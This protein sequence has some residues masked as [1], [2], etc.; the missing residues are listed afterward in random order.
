MM[1]VAHL[2]IHSFVGLGSHM[3]LYPPSVVP[4]MTPHVSMD[5]LL[6]LTI[7]AKW[8][9]TVIGPFGF[10]FIGQGNDSG[11][12][13]PHIALPPPN[14]LIP[15]IIAF[16][17]SKPMFSAST[18]KIDVD[19]AGVPMAAVCFPCNFVSM[20]QACN[21]PC[22]YPSDVVISPNSVVVGFTPGDYAAG[23]VGIAADSA[24]S[25]V[26]SK[27]GGAVAADVMSAVGGRIAS[28]M[29]RKWTQELTETFGE[30]FAKEAT[31]AAAEN[32]LE[33]VV[34]QVIQEAMGKVIGNEVGSVIT[35]TTDEPKGQPVSNSR[36][37]TSE[38]S[39]NTDNAAP[40]HVAD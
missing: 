38:L 3:A 33:R 4:V 24:V 23:L 6:G 25:F 14:V 28:A 18:V 35:S 40:I 5:T 30:K 37:S 27:I 11:L 36:S 31:E 21:D 29:L 8:S 22:N 39:N 13:V 7:G 32:M 19:G 1:H 15:V 9:K 20:N 17:G 16:G 10:Q 34:P 12:V 26:A 2:T